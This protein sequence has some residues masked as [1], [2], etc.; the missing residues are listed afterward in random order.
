MALRYVDPAAP[1][2]FVGRTGDFIA[3]TSAGRRWAK[4]SARV[5]PVLL[6]NTG[7]RVRLIGAIPS[8]HLLT[9]G[10]GQV[11][12]SVVYFH[13][14]DDVI[15]VASNYGRPQHAPWFLD[16]QADPSCRLNGE[17]FV[18]RE[19]TDELEYERMF[20]LAARITPVFHTFRDQAEA[21]GRH[22]PL[23]RLSAS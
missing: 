14:G 21:A 3:Q 10:P 9:N 13:D 23:L 17:P 11:E 8:L 20:R 18:A 6:R 2:G 1:K 12:A 4:V 22:V 16:L 19:I 5:D 15:L 7:G